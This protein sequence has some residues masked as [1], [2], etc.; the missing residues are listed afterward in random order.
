MSLSFKHPKHKLLSPS[1]GRRVLDD[2]GPQG[3]PVVRKRFCKRDLI[4]L[5]NRRPAALGGT[6]DGEGGHDG[7]GSGACSQAHGSEV[8]FAILMGRQKMEGRAVVPQRVRPSWHEFRDV[9]HHPRDAGRILPQPLLG[10]VDGL[11]GD[12]EHRYVCKPS[13]Q[14]V[15]D[16]EA[17]ASTHVENGRVQREFQRG[18]EVQGHLWHRLVPAAG[19]QRL[20]VV[21]GLPVGGAFRRVHAQRSRFPPACS[22]TWVASRVLAVRAVR[23]R[24]RCHGSTD[25][26]RSRN[27]GLD[28]APAR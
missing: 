18:D 10:A 12:V 28:I 27:S 7:L 20:G 16:H 24:R 2:R 11:G 21:D 9:R 13:L 19:F 6:V 14:E 1:A 15:I 23:G 3:R 25:W 4:V 8:C 17:V 22:G 5:L 26:R